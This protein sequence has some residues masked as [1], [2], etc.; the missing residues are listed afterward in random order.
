MK[1]N[2]WSDPKFNKTKQFHLNNKEFKICHDSL[3]WND[4]EYQ[5]WEYMSEYGYGGVSKLCYMVSRRTTGK[6]NNRE[7]D[8]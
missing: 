6:F 3:K 2:S 5:M 1:K 7:I 8:S 4:S